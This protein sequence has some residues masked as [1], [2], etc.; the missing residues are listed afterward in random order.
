MD[1][2]RDGERNDL[3]AALTDGTAAGWSTEFYRSADAFLSKRGVGVSL[4]LGA[5]KSIRSLIVY[6]PTRGWTGEL[7]LADA[8]ADTIG[9][10]GQPVDRVDDVAS[11]E[12]S[13]SAGG[14]TARYVLLWIT[15][16]GPNQR[17]TVTE[18][19]VRG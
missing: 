12:L 8:P 15:D 10:W 2:A 1:P 4:D 9:G 7:Y 14:R 11:T 16:L 6:T 13:L 18:L 5:P 19:G 17:V 3:L